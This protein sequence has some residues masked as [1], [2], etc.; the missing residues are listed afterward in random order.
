MHIQK[1]F[2]PRCGE[3]AEEGLCPRCRVAD[4]EWLV[5]E[6]RVTTIYCPTCD[7]QKR[8]KTW[9]DL[10]VERPELISELAISAVHL[11]QDVRDV[12]ITI[13][14]DE[15][16]PNRTNVA[17]GIDATLYGLPVSGACQ[18]EIVWQR[19]QCDRCSRISGGYYEGVIQVRATDRKI[20]A[21]EREVA[22]SIATQAEDSLQE[23][24]ERLS[25]V[26]SIDETRDGVD[27][28]VGTQRIG[29]YISQMITGA[30]G[31]RYTTHPKLVGEKD[32]RTLYRITYSIRLP[33][34]QKG[35]IV[36]SGKRYYE[37]RGVDTQ[38]L[39]V[40]DLATG[41]PKT[42]REA[43]IT[44][45]IGNI[46]DAESAIVAFTQGNTIGLL[47]PKT[48]ATREMNAVP[49]LTVAEGVPIRVVRDEEQEN[50]IIV[51]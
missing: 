44:R 25:F 17:V 20:N 51:G 41:I 35:D 37:I 14:S 38:H 7:S 4:T 18:V 24:G 47:D 6:P 19:E 27:I 36:V 48:Y 28:V 34:Y 15:P 10:H 12:S 29:Q 45:R 21:Y 39:T 1:T 42:L 46:R 33:F 23:G 3:P 32:G 16:T 13:R 2:C 50:L 26:T 30:L 43:D 49:W 5:C 9:S 22:T 8:G 40:F 31:G 11:H